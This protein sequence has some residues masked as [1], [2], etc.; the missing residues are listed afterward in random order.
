LIPPSIGDSTHSRTCAAAK[1]RLQRCRGGAEQRPC[2]LRQTNNL[3]ISPTQTAAVVAVCN[4]LVCRLFNS[5]QRLQS[6]RKGKGRTLMMRRWRRR[7]RRSR[8]SSVEHNWNE[9]SRAVL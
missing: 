9:N 7:R 1:C 3:G 5:L 8:S 2:V 6:K 4:A